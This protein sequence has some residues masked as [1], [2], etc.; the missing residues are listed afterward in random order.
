G[1]TQPEG[2]HSG[3]SATLVRQGS[4]SEV[5]VAVKTWP[6]GRSPETATALRTW[7]SGVAD[8]LAQPLHERPQPP[9]VRPDLVHEER[10][11]HHVAVLDPP[12]GGPRPPPQQ[13]DARLVPG[14]ATRSGLQRLPHDLPP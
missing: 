14:E 5:E 7:P 3:P 13:P 9:P 8:D 2:D 10:R 11:R 12:H 6:E 1:V 4:P